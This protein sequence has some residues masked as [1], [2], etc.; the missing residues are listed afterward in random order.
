[1]N[2]VQLYEGWN[3]NVIYLG[4]TQL[5]TYAI[6]NI[7]HLVRRIWVYRDGVWL[8]YDP[9][10]PYGTDLHD[11]RHGEAV[12]ILMLDDAFW[13]F[14][15]EEEPE[16]PPDIPPFCEVI[17]EV[18]VVSEAYP[19]EYVVNQTVA[20]KNTGGPGRC[21]IY[22]R[23]MS[24]STSFTFASMELRADEIVHPR[25][26]IFM[27][28][29]PSFSF[30]VTGESYKNGTWVVDTYTDRFT[31]KGLEPIEDPWEPPPDDEVPLAL[32]WVP[33]GLAA[34]GILAAVILGRRERR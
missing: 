15:Y 12:N 30:I 10:D 16:P 22:V 17:G 7:K 9:Y 3:E 18:H 31:V 33:I 26:A 11:L 1:M 20:I 21:R 32:P 24:P 6:A 27:P 2:G 23:D 19:K 29:A 4:P 13:I 28:D 34:G 25:L 14:D 8:M 5:V